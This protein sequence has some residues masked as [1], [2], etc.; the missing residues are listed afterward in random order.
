MILYAG[1]LGLVNGVGY[2]VRLAARLLHSAPEVRIAIVGGGREEEAVKRLAADLGVLGI[3]LFFVGPVSK[4]EIVAYFGACDLACSTVI[5]VPA[6]SANSANKVFDTWAA[7]KP[8]AINHDGWIAEIIRDTGAGV[9]MPPGR[10]DV[11]ASL[12][13]DFLADSQRMARARSAAAVLAQGRFSRDQ[14]FECLENVLR[15]AVT[16]GEPRTRAAVASASLSDV[17]HPGVRE[18]PA[19]PMGSGRPQPGS[20]HP[21]HAAF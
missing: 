17:K 13:A 21:S 18:H 14:L 15:S 16:P 11:A 9:V 7:G 1:T 19:A 8:V 12:V 6:L 10:P 3:N 4:S 5:D 2:L 20:P